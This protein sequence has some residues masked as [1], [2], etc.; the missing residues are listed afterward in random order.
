MRK[1]VIVVE[2]E[3]A[4]GEMLVLSLER[5]GFDA[6]LAQDSTKAK[7]ILANQSIDLALVDWMLPGASGIEFIRYLRADE[8]TR[9]LSLIHI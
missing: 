3:P 6:T 2:D 7:E 4:I 5:N 1:H 8:V 9:S